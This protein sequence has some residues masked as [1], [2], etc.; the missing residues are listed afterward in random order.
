MHHRTVVVNVEVFLPMSGVVPGSDEEKCH[1]GHNDLARNRNDHA[2]PPDW[3]VTE[4]FC[5]N[6]GLHTRWLN[7]E[8]F[9]LT[10]IG[11]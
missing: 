1:I 6:P 7:W 8:T 9:C 10:S 5:I 11:S 2:V 4:V 3:S